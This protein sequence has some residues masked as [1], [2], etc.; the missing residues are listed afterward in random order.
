MTVYG[1]SN[2]PELPVLLEKAR[3]ELHASE[4]RFRNVVSRLP[5]GIVVLDALGMVY[6]A[7]PAALR[8]ISQP[9]D[10]FFRDFNWRL[11]IGK[12]LIHE[13]KTSGKATTYEIQV[14]ETE[15]DLKKA[16]LVTLHDITVQKEK[17]NNL[18]QAIDESEARTAEL[19]IMQFVA[20]QLNQAALLE[21]TIQSGL[22]MIQ[23]LSGSKKVWALLADEN[24]PPHLVLV[25]R[26]SQEKNTHR[27]LLEMPENCTC[28]KQL[29]AGE[30][31]GFTHIKKCEWAKSL[32]G[33][34]LKTEEHLTFPLLVNNKTIGVLNLAAE[35]DKV[36]S[37]Y[38]IN[39]LETVCRELAAAI[40][41]G[42]TL[43]ETSDALRRDESI[44]N[45][46]RTLSS[47]IDLTTVLQNVIR[48]SAD[49]IRA[50]IGL[51]GLLSND[52]STLTFPFNF[53]LPADIEIPPLARTGSLIWNVTSKCEGYFENNTHGSLPELPAASR[54]KISSELAVPIVGSGR[55][56]GVISLYKTGHE[57]VFTR[58][59]Q[60][61]LESLAR[62]AGM[63]I[64]NAELY[65][66]V[67]QLTTID[68]LTRVNNR[69]SFVNLAVKE[70]ERSWRYGRPLSLIMVDIDRLTDYNQ[71][72][73]Y[74]A[75][76]DAL[77]AL[78]QACSSSLRRVDIL[79]RYQ[80]DEMVLLLPETDLK[81][82]TD[83]AERLRLQI[84]TIPLATPEGSSAITASMGLT[85]VEGRQEIDLQTLLDRAEM[86]LFEAKK[87]G[88][89]RVV[90]WKLE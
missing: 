25:D 56:L 38:D 53:G 87:N 80:N 85:G 6:F 59:D 43:S 75:G 21:E 72:Y 16:F 44:N 81:N 64:I 86:A 46:T 40:E 15:W 10:L 89:N 78:A 54:D 12:T 4:A 63:A 70:V 24:N 48:L 57:N 8:L 61:M 9:P 52:Q 5:E 45:F 1:A 39:L 30:L 83:V 68:P 31:N 26:Q 22:E 27:A 71:A 79:G 90:A 76:N 74:E 7:N 23:T 66:K 67:Q 32:F 47:T 49:L 62:Q 34:D 41:R 18:Q 69:L 28:L 29:L 50:D 14:T 55:C 20:E 84:A 13:A 77:R 60:T 37:P 19:E 88:R 58:F 35:P 33:N 36:Y 42:R 2:Q 82:A 65:F 11:G 51:L 17:E 3:Q 73:G